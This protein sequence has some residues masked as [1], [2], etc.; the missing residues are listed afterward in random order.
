MLPLPFVRLS[1]AALPKAMLSEPAMSEEKVPAPTAV[2]SVPTTVR[3]EL[4]PISVFALPIVNWPALKPMYVL[5]WS[6]DE[7]TPAA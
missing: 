4:T 5:Y 2:L 3:A 1:P 6:L 7:A